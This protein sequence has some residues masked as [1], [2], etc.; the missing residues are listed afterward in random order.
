MQCDGVDA[1]VVLRDTAGQEAYAAI[2]D[3]S[4]KNCRCFMLCFAMPQLLLDGKTP[5]HS[6]ANAENHVRPAP[7]FGRALRGRCQPRA[8]DDADGNCARAQWCVQLREKGYLRDAKIV[9]VGT[10]M[11]LVPPAEMETRLQN[12]A[13]LVR[14]RRQV[15]R[16]G[17][18][19][20]RPG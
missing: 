6:L 5:N 14:P 18:I 10:Q 19:A 17:A 15:L 20:G 1:M 9:L 11:D 2:N 4:F 7:P 3:A 12:A 8:P 16:R 13:L